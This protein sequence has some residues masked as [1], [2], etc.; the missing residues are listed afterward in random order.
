MV[1]WHPAIAR[2]SE[3]ELVQSITARGLDLA[4]SA[5]GVLRFERRGLLRNAAG[6]GP[7]AG[8]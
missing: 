2:C 3:D 6:T 4:T 1:E 5:A 8:R 7:R